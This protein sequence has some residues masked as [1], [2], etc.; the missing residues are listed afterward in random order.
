MN[1]DFDLHDN[2]R[3]DKTAKRLVLTPRHETARKRPAKT[4]LKLFLQIVHKTK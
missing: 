3:T 4:K 1:N 2:K